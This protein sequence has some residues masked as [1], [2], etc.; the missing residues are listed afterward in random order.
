MGAT[1]GP[2]DGRITY[3]DETLSVN[4][5]DKIDA[6]VEEAHNRAFTF[7]FTKIE[8]N[9]MVLKLTSPEYDLM[10]EYHV[11]LGEDKVIDSFLD[12]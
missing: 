2:E 3:Y 10:D 8:E 11:G 9:E 6:V 1:G 5:G 4:S 7:K 12:D